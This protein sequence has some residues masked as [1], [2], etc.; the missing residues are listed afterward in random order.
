MP[1]VQPKALASIHGK[2]NVRIRATVDA[3]GNVSDAT[4]DSEGPSPYFAKAA[5]QAAQKW[6]FKTAQTAPGAWILQ[7][8]FTR[9]GAAVT[10]EAAH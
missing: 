9:A 7:F 1:D 6:K 2:F 10:A 8:Q 5:L 4:F 3:G